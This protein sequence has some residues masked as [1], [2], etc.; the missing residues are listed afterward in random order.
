MYVTA[1]VFLDGEHI[2]AGYE[3]PHGPGKDETG[4]IIE[5]GWT[6]QSADKQKDYRSD[7]SNYEGQGRS[8]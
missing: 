5:P 7:Q 3:C 6:V 8:V 1:C 4:D 2:I